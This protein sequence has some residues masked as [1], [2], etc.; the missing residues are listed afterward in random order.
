MKNKIREMNDEHAKVY[1]VVLNFPFYIENLNKIL[2]ELPENKEDNLYVDA[3]CGT[4]NLVK[5]A[6]HKSYNFIGLDL[7]NEMLKRAKEKGIEDLFKIDITCLP[8]TE[9]SIDGITSINVL[10]QLRE[11]KKFLE[12]ARRVLKPKGKIIIL[13]PDKNASLLNFVPATLKSIVKNPRIL[14]NIKD[15]MTYF[16]INQGIINENPGFYTRHEL[17][18]MVRESGFE[19]EKIEKAYVDQDWLIVARKPT[20]ET[21]EE[22]VN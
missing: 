1:D 18:K 12:E 2:N 16:K 17:E 20:K 11:P 22:K 10:Y 13:T 6:Q 7:S 19:I 5:L 8:F 9:N 14:L 3:G 21:L 15:L 4:G